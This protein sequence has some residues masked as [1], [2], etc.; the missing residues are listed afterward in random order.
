[1]SLIQGG[2]KDCGQSELQKGRRD[3]SCTKPIGIGTL[4][5]LARFLRYQ[6]F[7]RKLIPI[8]EIT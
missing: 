4:M 6:H 1:V 8:C 2:C 7:R 3:R 5:V